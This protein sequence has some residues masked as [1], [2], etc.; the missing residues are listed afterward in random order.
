MFR[1]T[2]CNGVMIGRAVVQKPWLFAEILGKPP[3]ITA[4]FLWE[5]YQEAWRLISDFYPEY[6]ALGRLKE[7]T[8]YFSKNLRFGHRM[9]ARMQNLPTLATCRDLV[10]QEF[11]RCC[12]F[13]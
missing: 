11:V 7:F 13:P 6:Q 4:T 12:G 8:W 3:E 1:Q 2:G 10:D 9:A 5:T